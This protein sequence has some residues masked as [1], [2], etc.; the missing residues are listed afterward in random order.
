M[1]YVQVLWKRDLLPEA[2]LHEVTNATRE[3]VAEAITSVDPSHPVAVEMVDLKVVI[4]ERYDLIGPDLYVT[5][6]ARSEPERE[7][8]KAEIIDHI[9]DGIASTSAPRNTL[10]ELVLTNRVS[11]YDYKAE[12][13]R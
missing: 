3:F 9:T 10:V 2:D 4:V 5:V 7:E 8:N 1:P 13:I 6:L 11:R 12:S